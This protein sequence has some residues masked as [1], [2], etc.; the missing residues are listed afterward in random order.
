MGSSEVALLFFF[1]AF[2]SENWAIPER[3]SYFLEMLK[4]GHNSTPV[5]AEGSVLKETRFSHALLPI[6]GGVPL[7]GL[8]TQRKVKW[9]NG[10]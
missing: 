4:G 7:V 6:S 9:K 2:A 5:S 8:A 10:S 1:F 3:A